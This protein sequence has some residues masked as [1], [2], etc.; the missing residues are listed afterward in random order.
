MGRVWL[1]QMPETVRAVGVQRVRGC[2]MRR[3]IVPSVCKPHVWEA[4]CV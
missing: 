1:V 2:V 3:G 4:R